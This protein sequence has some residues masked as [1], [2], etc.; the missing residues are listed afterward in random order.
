MYATKSNLLRGRS[1]KGPPY[2]ATVENLVQQVQ[3]VTERDMTSRIRYLTLFLMLMYIFL[4]YFWANSMAGVER[5]RPLTA[6]ELYLS[7]TCANTDDS[8]SN[9]LPPTPSV[10]LEKEQLDLD[11]E[12]EFNGLL[13][14]SQLEG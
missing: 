4:A 2:D 13:S 7:C 10:G 9:P 12:V 3:Y 6:V 14:G 11:I 8:A 1:A 5:V